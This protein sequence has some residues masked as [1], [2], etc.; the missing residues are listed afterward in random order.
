MKRS[1]YDQ[2]FDKRTSNLNVN[3][4]GINYLRLMETRFIGNVSRRREDGETA[5]IIQRHD[6]IAV[7][8][9]TSMIISISMLLLNPLE[10]SV[11][12]CNASI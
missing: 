3:Q 10:T 2:Q 6:D 12:K 9:V 8:R 7:G 1:N 5:T 11:Q 4:R